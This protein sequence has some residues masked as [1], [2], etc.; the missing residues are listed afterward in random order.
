MNHIELGKKGETIAVNHLISNDYHILDRNY[1]W[2]NSELDIICVK[3]DMLI[4]VEVKT[5][6]TSVFGEPYL[7]VNRSKQR[8][9]IKVTNKYIELNGINMEV[10]FDV[11]SIVLNK[12]SMDLEHIENAFYPLYS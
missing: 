12:R 11:I 3:D 2:K 10:R 7:S 9:L 6:S 8:Q 1:R 4:I 5:R